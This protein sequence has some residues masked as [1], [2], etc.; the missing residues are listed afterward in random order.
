MSVSMSASTSVINVHEAKSHLSAVLARV[1]RGES[2]VIARAGKPVARLEPYVPKSRL[3][4][5]FLDLDIPDSV[6]FDPLD[7]EEL[8]AWE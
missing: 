4:G 2:V 8:V 7:E 6:F 5:G 1:E 3:T